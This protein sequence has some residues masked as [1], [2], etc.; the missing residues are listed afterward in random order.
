MRVLRTELR[1]YQLLLD[2]PET[3]RMAKWCLYLGIT[4]LLS[5]IDLIPDFIPGL[6]QLDD[7]LIVGSLVLLAK[8]LTP[9]HIL[10]D[11]RDAASG[12]ER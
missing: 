9:A 3:P 4:Y 5:P 2:N 7:L 1:F 6:G 8:W 12:E 11:C 10:S